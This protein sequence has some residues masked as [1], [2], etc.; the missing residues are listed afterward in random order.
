MRSEISPAF[1]QAMQRLW[2][3]GS[4]DATG[5]VDVELRR[6]YQLIAKGKAPLTEADVI[7]LGQMPEPQLRLLLP[8]LSHRLS[9]AEAQDHVDLGE[10]A[11]SVIIEE[12]CHGR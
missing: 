5:R 7:K 8:W 11:P 1:D 2:D 4:L 10:I 12:D 6:P 9:L 3:V